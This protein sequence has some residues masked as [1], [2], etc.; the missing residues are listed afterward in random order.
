MQMEAQLKGNQFI[1]EGNKQDEN[2]IRQTN[3][4]AW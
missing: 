4:V 3:E 1:S 2:L